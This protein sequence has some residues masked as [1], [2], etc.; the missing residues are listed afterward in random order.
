MII[1]FHTHTFPAK[2]AGNVLLH[3]Q[4]KSRS[5]PFTDATNDGL[6]RSM[7]AAGVDVSILLP[8]MTNTGQVPKLN[9]AAARTNE[10][11]R[12]TGLLS[13]GG[14]HPDTSDYREEL[15]R[16]HAMGIPG[17]KL[18]PAYQGADFDDIRY[19]RIIDRAAE[20]GLIVL[21]H[22]GWDIGIPGHNYCSTVHVRH[23]MREVGPDKLVLAHMG[24]WWDWE[25]VGTELSGLPIYFDTAFS[26]GDILPAPGTQRT[27]EESHNMNREQFTKLVRQLGTDRILFAT[28]CPWSGQ[29]ESLQFVQDCGFSEQEL[30]DI[31]GNNAQKLLG[32]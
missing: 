29:S 13:F 23:V 14:M 9:D 2:I 31:L 26:T 16:I 30:A 8:V 20:L 19:L 1:D 27:P 12:E 18:H 4:H 3:L 32:I 24:G 7:D 11:W 22:A 6:R 10:H 28:D 15:A 5:K 17:I 21:T 25:T